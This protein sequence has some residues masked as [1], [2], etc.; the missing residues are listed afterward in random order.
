M[1]IQSFFTK[2]G[3]GVLSLD[4]EAQALGLPGWGPADPADGLITLSAGSHYNINAPTIS[5]ISNPDPLD[6]EPNIMV[7]ALGEED[8][9]L[10]VLFASGSVQLGAGQ[11]S[12]VTISTLEEIGMI[13][14]DWGPDGILQLQ[15]G[16]EKEPNFMTMSPE[17]VILSSAELI[18]IITDENTI[19]VNPEEGITLTAGESVIT[20][21]PEGIVLTSGPSSIEISAEGITL[22]GPTIT[23]SGDAEV[24]VAAPAVS[25]SE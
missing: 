7:H 24:A 8:N 15:S 23:V 25:V 6:G 2:L 11:Q 12:L 20:L 17:G 18:T 16:P 13:T 5:L 9:G 3:A 4:Q 21:S 1:R 22:N 10:I 14:L 19:V